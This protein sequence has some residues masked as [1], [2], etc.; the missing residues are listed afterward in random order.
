MPGRS[1]AIR[2]SRIRGVP[3]ICDRIEPDCSK[4]VGV[5]SMWLNSKE[6]RWYFSTTLLPTVCWRTILARGLLVRVVRCILIASSAQIPLDKK[7]QYTKNGKSQNENAN[8]KNC[9]SDVPGRGYGC[10]GRDAKRR[11]RWR[12]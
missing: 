8:A 10:V 1:S 4:T 7:S 2:A 6:L 12:G 3:P 9:F 11:I 5:F